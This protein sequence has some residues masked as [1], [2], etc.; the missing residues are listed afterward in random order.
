MQLAKSEQAGEK[1]ID[2][3]NSQTD[4]SDDFLSMLPHRSRAGAQAAPVR[5]VG[6]GLRVDIEHSAKWWG[7]T[8]LFRALDRQNM[9]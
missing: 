8:N 4:S 5:E 3:L 2:F 1:V 6:L 9:H 7:K